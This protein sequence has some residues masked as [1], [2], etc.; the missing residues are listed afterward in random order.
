MTGIR[1]HIFHI[2]IALFLLAGCSSETVST[3]EE[4]LNVEK[5]KER[6]AYIF[7]TPTSIKVLN[8]SLKE[9]SLLNISDTIFEAQID[10][11][12]YLRGRDIYKFSLDNFTITK[13]GNIPEGISDVA[14]TETGSIFLF[15]HEIV[16]KNEYSQAVLLKSDNKL[17]SLWKNPYH[18][19]V[20]ALD[21][22]GYLYSIDY[23]RRI[24]KKKIF[25]GNVR[26]IDFYKLGTRIYVLTPKTFLLL[27]YETLN[28]IYEKKQYLTDVA[29][30]PSSGF[31]YLIDNKNKKIDVV[32]SINY[33][34]AG[35][36]SLLDT[37][38]DIASNR[39]SSVCIIE[40]DNDKLKCYKA[41][42]RTG[43]IKMNFEP[44]SIF[45]YNDTIVF[46][47]ANDSVYYGSE[48]SRTFTSLLSSD[49]ILA[50]FS[51]RIRDSLPSAIEESE[52]EEYDLFKEEE[53]IRDNTYYSIQIRS[54]RDID[55]AKK[56]ADEDRQ[57]IINHSVFIK[58]AI[59]ETVPY[60]RVYAGKFA[61][62]KDAENLKEL[63]IKIGY[64][65]DI[66]IRPIYDKDIIQ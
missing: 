19:Y 14:F 18:P 9:H 28:I 50:M 44:D 39:D 26:S 25:A 38:I 43:V 35:A 52:P 54:F 42:K 12:I 29:E 2:L 30:T 49:S 31:M 5:G 24:L 15:D 33:S 34:D 21:S 64:S 10:N 7:I 59:I 56:A 36:I 47:H 48:G 60:Y 66:L 55:A 65:R 63:L 22:L 23:N 41:N 3:P 17:V 62:K 58:K 27:D 4:N 45:H 6:Y 20:Y 37:V 40:A 57:K 51:F 8:D 53:V 1:Q 61:S 13:M 32:S 46:L 11:N 16:M